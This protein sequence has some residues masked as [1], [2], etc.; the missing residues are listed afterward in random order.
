[1]A[2]SRRGGGDKGTDKGIHGGAR[3]GRRRLVGLDVV[4]GAQ[5]RIGG[6]SRREQQQR[7]EHPKTMTFFFHKL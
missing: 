6:S 2:I 7:L 4:L 5:L 1:M 3:G